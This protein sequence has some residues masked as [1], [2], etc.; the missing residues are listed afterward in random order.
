M[1]D[2]EIAAKAIESG[3]IDGVGIGR[4]LLAVPTGRKSQAGESSRYTSLYCL[5]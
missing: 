2:P 5:S 1:E 3:N 4:Q